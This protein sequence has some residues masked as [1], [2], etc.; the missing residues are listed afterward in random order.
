MALYAVRRGVPKSD[1][2]MDYA[3]RRTYDTCYRARKIF[4]V[5]K[6][7]LVT[8]GFH[9]PRALFTCNE[10]GVKSVGVAS[11]QHRYPR[12]LYL[13]YRFREIFASFRAAVDVYLLKPV[14]VL[15]PRIDIWA[16]NR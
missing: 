11:D 13:K 10:L 2:V 14:P 5:E 16:K 7:V 9:M 1:V 4:G 12:S 15:G 8:Q 3:G 6:A